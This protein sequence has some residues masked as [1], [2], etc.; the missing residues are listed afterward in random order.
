MAHF[1]SGIQGTR[2]EGN[3]CG[4]KSSG[5]AAFVQS[6]TGRIE[7]HY[8]HDFHE[9]RD[10]ACVVLTT[11][12][13]GSGRSTDITGNIDV[14]ALVQAASFD[15]ETGRHLRQAQASMQRANAAAVKACAKRDKLSRKAA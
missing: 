12:P 13:S 15:A 9:D 3:R 11:G 2:G 5:I 7:A 6:W 1:Y 10:Y 8:D 14:A 4:T